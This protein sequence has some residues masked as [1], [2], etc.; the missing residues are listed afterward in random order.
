MKKNEYTT[1]SGGIRYYD[2]E[3]EGKE[4]VEDA[5][6]LDAAIAEGR[7]AGEVMKILREV[8]G[9]L[10]AVLARSIRLGRLFYDDFLVQTFPEK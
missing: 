6:R 7:P 10:P 1:Y 2:S 8:S 4:A 9:R 5:E 3:K